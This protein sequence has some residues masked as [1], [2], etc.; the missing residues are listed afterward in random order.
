LDDCKVMLAGPAAEQI[1]FG[2]MGPGGDNDRAIA[3]WLAEQAALGGRVDGFLSVAETRAE[4]LLRDNWTRVEALVL[5]LLQ[6]AELGGA[7]VE[8]VTGLRSCDA[9]A[10]A[11]ISTR[12]TGPKTTTVT[13]VDMPIMYRDD[14]YVVR[15]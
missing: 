5:E 7:A 10:D 6:H 14:G 13:Y 2:A 15:R 3:R 4:C 9:S 12:K 8:A 1:R 11:E